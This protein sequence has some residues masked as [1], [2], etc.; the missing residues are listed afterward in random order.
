M[1]FSSTLA[2]K[3]SS[4]ASHMMVG[5]SAERSGVCHVFCSEGWEHLMTPACIP[6]I[7]NLSLA[8]ED[9]AGVGS[10]SQLSEMRKRAPLIKMPDL[11]ENCHLEGVMVSLQR[12]V[13][14]SLLPYLLNQMEVCWLLAQTQHAVK[15]AHGWTRKKGEIICSHMGTA[16]VA[17][18]QECTPSTS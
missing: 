8:T 6:T 12:L 1:S 15:T 18:G 14:T 4:A 16:E 7:L 3:R 9:G 13:D 2:L 11:V 5:C 17:A 10:H